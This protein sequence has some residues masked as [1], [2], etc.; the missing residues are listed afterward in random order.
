M[1]GVITLLAAFYILTTTSTAALV[2]DLSLLAIASV[3]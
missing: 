2:V 1:L 3:M